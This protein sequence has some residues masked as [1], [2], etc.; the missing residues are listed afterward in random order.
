MYV[1]VAYSTSGARLVHRLIYVTGFD[2]GDF[3]SHSRGCGECEAAGQME[4]SK[5][6]DASGDVQSPRPQR[7]VPRRA[8]E[9]KPCES[10]LVCTLDRLSLLKTFSPHTADARRK[11]PPQRLSQRPNDIYV[12]R[13]SDFAGQLARCHRLLDQG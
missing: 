3:K 5:G 6:S 10:S 7:K 11:R 12:N 2:S 9:K 4:R 13:K 8:E 1:R